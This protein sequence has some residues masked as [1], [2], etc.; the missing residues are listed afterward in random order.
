MLAEIERLAG[1][2]VREVTLLGQNVNS[3][4]RDL[5]TDFAEDV[6]A[7]LTYQTPAWVPLFMTF[8]F[9]E[10]L[11]PDPEGLSL[12]LQ[13]EAPFLTIDEC[14]SKLGKTPLNIPGVTDVPWAVPGSQPMS[15][16]KDGNTP[17]PRKAAPPPAAPPTPATP[18][19]PGA[20]SITLERLIELVDA[21]SRSGA[22]HA[23]RVLVRS[24]SNG[25]EAHEHDD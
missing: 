4:G 1:E 12:V 2:G 6:N 14:R 3:Y 15:A 13:R 20:S 21:D 18:S 19:R 8:L 10:Q 9:E 5:G 24:L 7:Q 23:E 22:D 17:A 16:W 25:S 11:Q